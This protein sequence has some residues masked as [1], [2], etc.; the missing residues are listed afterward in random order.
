MTQQTV[1]PA[2]HFSGKVFLDIGGAG[3]IGPIDVTS[4]Q[5]KPD[6]DKRTLTSKQNGQYG[7]ARVTYYLGKPAQITIKTTDIPP[8]M[9]APAFMGTQVAINQA[10]GSL[11][12]EAV[13]LPAYPGW[14]KLSKGNLSST[15]LSVKKTSTALPETD[16]EVDYALGLI[17]ASASGSLKD[18]GDIS[19]TATYNA[20]S[21]TRI[22]GNVK[23]FVTASLLMDG[24]N[25]V[26][27][28]AMHLEIPSC[29]LSP[30]G[31]LDFLSE[32]AIEVTLSG[33]LQV[34]AGED[35]AFYVDFPEPV[36][37]P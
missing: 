20:I 12:D 11:T 22:R 25:L 34:K 14:A 18:G 6:A 2:L 17:R 3:L 36:A 37:A 28:R 1:S 35:A 33:E 32:N 9:L 16:Y 31:E 21:G 4:L 27:D 5:I 13:T 8:T 29:T 10:S 15:G 26:D 7:N 30:S 23:P 19:V 24:V